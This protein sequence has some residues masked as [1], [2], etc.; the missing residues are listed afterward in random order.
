MTCKDCIH[1]DV[2][3][4]PSIT[5]D[6]NNAKDCG[7]FKNKADYAE[8]KHGKWI[9]GIPY[10]CSICGKPAPDEKNTSE[11]YSCW[12]SPHCPHCGAQ[13]NVTDTNVGCK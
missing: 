8:V 3:D 4:I 1:Y 2:C 9:Q 12:T 13:M 5:N 11:R 6:I 10:V 7:K